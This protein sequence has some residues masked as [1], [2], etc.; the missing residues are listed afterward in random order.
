MHVL[1]EKLQKWQLHPLGEPKVTPTSIIQYCRDQNQKKVLKIPIDKQEKIGCQ[2]MSFYKGK[3]SAMVYNFDHCAIVMEYIPSFPLVH[4]CG[5]NKKKDLNATRIIANVIL[6]IHQNKIDYTD[7]ELPLLTQW[8]S[9]IIQ[10]EFPRDSLYY[11]AK[12]ITLDLFNKPSN[13]YVLHGDIHHLNIGITRKNKWVAIDP[14]GVIGP[15]EFDYA[16]ILCNPNSNLA[17]QPGRLK[18]HISLIC[19][20]AHIEYQTL[21]EWV[22][23]WSALS[24]LWKV[25]DNL[26]ASLALGIAK[27]ALDLHAKIK[28]N[29]KRL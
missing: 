19:Q 9:P 29:K 22:I 7:L 12:E 11:K 3:G 14:K 25:E 26:D 2:L 28:D 16:N 15:R 20:I 18:K 5:L 10:E 13:D 6:E 17:L 4:Y 8:F 23:A 24:A 1:E 27:N 21:V